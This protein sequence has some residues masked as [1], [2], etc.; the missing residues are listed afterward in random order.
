MDRE[1]TTARLRVG[2]IARLRARRSGAQA[3][4]GSAAPAPAVPDAARAPEPTGLGDLS[5]VTATLAR[6]GHEVRVAD[7]TQP[8]DVPAATARQALLVLGDVAAVLVRC[9]GSDQLVSVRVRTEDDQ[10][11]VAV[12]TLPAGP[13]P[14]PIV[15]AARDEQLL[16]R[17][18]ESAAGRAT[19][20][21]THGG[22]W[23]VMA[24]LPLRA[25]SG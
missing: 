13:R 22:N 7:R 1:P 9:A 16:R 24:R 6:H 25:G 15:L 23:I 4:H 19:V 8:G 18:V 12:Q 17:R 2:R 5:R 11:V 21:T 14:K 20:R 10:L 3:K